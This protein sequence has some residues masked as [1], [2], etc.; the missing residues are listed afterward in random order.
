MAEKL[1]TVTLPD[2]GEGVVEG[3]VIRWLKHVGDS[4]GRDEPVVVVMTDKAT[5]ELPAPVA[6]TL[7]ATYYPE[8]AIALVGRPLYAIAPAVSAEVESPKMATAVAASSAHALTPAPTPP[9][10]LSIATMP[11]VEVDVEVKR[12]LALPSTRHLAKKL[13][14]ELSAVTATGS[15]GRITDE[16]LRSFMQQH[17]ETVTEFKGEGEVLTGVKR[18]MFVK[19][20]RAKEAIPHFSYFE[21][22]DATRL[23]QLRSHLMEEAAAEGI[24]LT[25]MPLF[26][27]ALSLTLSRY[28]L[29][30]S[31]VDADHYTVYKHASH[32]IGIAIAT[33][34]GLIVP[35]LHHVENMTLALLIRSYEVLKHKAHQGTIAPEEMR[36]GT[37]TISNFGVL[38]GEGVWATPII[39]PP[40]VAILAVAKI[41]PLPVARGGDVVV[42]NLLPLSW[43][44]DHRIIDGAMAAAASHYFAQLL[45]NPAMLLNST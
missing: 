13:G 6:G 35:V 30:N 25:Y 16:D 28:P 22:V 19:M 43:S 21:R 39:N 11:S 34:R 20:A 27:K 33:E 44:F 18:A 23:I 10:R 12:P 8:G 29:L 32:N 14:I 1:V 7:A 24:H 40:E 9:P 3:E 26:L 45:Y 2:I 15:D 41:T 4:I 31:S 42:R 37:I 36:Q 17:K 38:G 5:V